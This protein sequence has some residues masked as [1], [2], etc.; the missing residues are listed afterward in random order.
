MDMRVHI[1]RHMLRRVGECWNAS[2]KL[3]PRKW[4]VTSLKHVLSNESI[5]SIAALVT[6]MVMCDH[7]SFKLSLSKNCLIKKNYTPKF[8]MEPE[9][10]SLEKEIPFGNHHFQVPC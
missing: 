7:V 2:R 8:Y 9:K 1:C 3:P 10:N 4:Y 5:L 6:S